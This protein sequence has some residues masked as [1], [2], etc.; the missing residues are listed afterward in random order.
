MGD[1]VTVSPTECAVVQIF[2]NDGY[3]DLPGTLPFQI[4]EFDKLSCGCGLVT[5]MNALNGRRKLR[6]DMTGESRKE[7]LAYLQTEHNARRQQEMESW[8]LIPV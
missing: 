6:K 8:Q 1:P 2:E 7:F 3:R 5:T 4:G